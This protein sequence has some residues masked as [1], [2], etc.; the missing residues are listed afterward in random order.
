MVGLSF[1]NPVEV[2]FG[3]GDLAPP[4]EALKAQDEMNQG[5]ASEVPDF[6]MYSL[7]DEY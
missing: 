4:G 7:A 5:L 2:V 3:R 1:R 6:R